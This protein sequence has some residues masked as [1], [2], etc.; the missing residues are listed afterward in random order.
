MI[1]KICFFKAGEALA[2]N[3]P[4][5]QRAALFFLLPLWAFIATHMQL[6]CS[7]GAESDKLTKQW[8]EKNAKRIF[9]KS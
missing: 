9:C 4:K 1:P 7:T 3:F 2:F 6:H 5:N 8:E